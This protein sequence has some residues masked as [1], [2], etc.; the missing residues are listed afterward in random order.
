MANRMLLL[1]LLSVGLMAVAW[2][3]DTAAPATAKASLP[4][5]TDVSR[6]P[7]TAVPA[8]VPPPRIPAPGGIQILLLYTD[9][10]GSPLEYWLP[11]FPG[12]AA[13]DTW[14]IGYNDKLPLPTVNDLLAYDVVISW[15][16]YSYPDAVAAGDLL[17]DYVDA[18][19]RLILSVFNFS[20]NWGIQ[21]QILDGAHSPFLPGNYTN[22]YTWGML[23]TYD[24][25]H[26][27]MEG[28]TLAYDYYRDYVIVVP[29]PMWWPTG[30]R[31]A[32]RRCWPTTRS[33]SPPWGPWWA[34][35]P[36]RDRIVTGTKEPR[37]WP[38]ITTMPPCTS[39]A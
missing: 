31:P 10:N 7:H 38:G 35:T 12:V 4:K 19:G 24:A 25:T 34:S 18:G 21:S 33:S 30:N 28:Q 13:V 39:W 3:G 32:A 37:S 17:A 1:I 2:A 22:H 29:G 26:P 23:G 14:Q 16:N 6:P 36:T 15:S 9:D 8:P 11:T 20:T 27:I 5:A